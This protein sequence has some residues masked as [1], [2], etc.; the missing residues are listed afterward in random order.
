MGEPIRKTYLVRV[1]DLK[2]IRPEDLGESC[3][4]E[5]LIYLVGSHVECVVVRDVRVRQQPQLREVPQSPALRVRV[6]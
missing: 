4:P 5:E 6:A 3:D 2:P 1:E